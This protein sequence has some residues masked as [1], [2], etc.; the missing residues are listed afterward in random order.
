MG[1]AHPSVCPSVHPVCTVDS[2]R[3]KKINVPKPKVTGV[4]MFSSND[5]GQG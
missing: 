4:S 5:N 2:E 1:L 3:C